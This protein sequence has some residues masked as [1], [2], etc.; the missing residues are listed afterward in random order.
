MRIM[1][2]FRYCKVIMTEKIEPYLFDS[3]DYD[4]ERSVQL[5][6]IR[7]KDMPPEQKDDFILW[8][9]ADLHAI[10]ILGGAFYSDYETW[11][12]AWCIDK[13]VPHEDLGFYTCYR[14]NTDDNLKT[15]KIDPVDYDL[16][17]IDYGT[18]TT[19]SIVRFREL[20]RDQRNAFTLWL[21]TNNRAACT[22]Q[23]AYYSEY[24]TWYDAWCKI[25]QTDI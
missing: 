11:Y 2:C 19:V 9:D 17:D 5:R 21:D 6:I 18:K 24:V 15:S 23:Y 1:N 20:P 8:N 22:L 12:G 25:Q 13:T 7:Y 16:R 3:H 14:R 10:P 4:I